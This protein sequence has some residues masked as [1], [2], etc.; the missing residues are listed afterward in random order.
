MLAA[1]GIT[2]L[3]VN[4]ESMT[5]QPKAGGEAKTASHWKSGW[6][7]IILYLQIRSPQIHLRT[8]DTS[9]SRWR[10][11]SYGTQRSPFTNF[12]A[13]FWTRAG[14]WK[15][16]KRKGDDACIFKMRASKHFVEGEENAWGKGHEGSFQHYLQ[17]WASCLRQ[18]SGLL[19][20]KWLG[21]SG[22]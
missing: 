1:T 8:R 16:R 2:P 13:S 10:A 17:R 20:W 14:A 4:L 12:T 6:P 9:R 5:A 19:W 7:C 22:Y 11:E 3:L 21:L 15:S 18:F